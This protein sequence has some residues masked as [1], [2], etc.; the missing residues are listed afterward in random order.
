MVDEA[1][2]RLAKTDVKI[3][4]LAGELEGTKGTAKPIEA[5]R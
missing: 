4:A 3:E 2:G 1:E 5:G